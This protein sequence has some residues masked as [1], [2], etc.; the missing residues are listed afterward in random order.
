MNLLKVP[1][2]YLMFLKCSSSTA[3]AYGRITGRHNYTPQQYLSK[4]PVR[5]PAAIA[6]LSQNFPNPF[7]G[8]N[9]IYGKTISRANLLKPYP[10]FGSIQEVD[11][12]GYAWYHSL[13]TRIERRFSQGFHHSTFLHLVE[14]HGSHAVLERWRCPAL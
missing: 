4:S 11:P 12:V 3:Q 7:F 2:R 9:S 6:F 8:L 13:Q 10:E 5:D 1:A 14:S